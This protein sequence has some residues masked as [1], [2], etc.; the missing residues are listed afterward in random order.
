MNDSTTHLRRDVRAIF[1]AGLAAVDPEAAV[2]RHLVRRGAQLHAGGRT[3]DLDAFRHVVLIGAGKAGAPM[4]AAVEAVV[5]DRITG[6][7]VVVKYGHG[8]PL[9]HVKLIEAGHPVPDEN[10]VA[11]A[12]AVLAAAAGAGPD[13]LVIGLIS[14][15]G[16]SLLTRPA[17]GLT[18]AD[19]Q[20]TTRVLLECGATIHEINTLRKHLSAVKGGHLAQAVFPA[21]MITL[22]LSDVVGDDLD[23]IASG[24]TVPDAGT[25]ADCLSI[26]R[27][28]GI[29][30]RL[31]ATVR[32]YI[33]TGAAGHHCETPKAG[34]PV[35]KAAHNIVV[36]RNLDAL[37]AA[38]DKA[39]TLGYRPLVLSSQIQGETRQVAGVH[40]AI[41]RE[42]CQSGQPIPPP[43][44]ILSG[45]ETTVTMDYHGKGGRNQ[46]F[47]LAAALDI[48]GWAQTV[49]L[50]GGTD[51]T[52]GPTDAAGAVVDGTT[53]ARAEAAGLDARSH[54]AGHDAYPFFERLG[55]LLITGPTRTNVMDLRVMLVGGPGRSSH[56]PEA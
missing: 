26:V 21:V 31:P 11:G 12:D 17:A 18:L 25:F 22:I 42:V 20:A 15:G 27:R 14:G 51:G 8:A 36:G 29:E 34:D 24:P 6:G 2:S 50:S 56:L 32:R 48:A 40:A 39:A 13:S 41:A 16:S 1:D 44:C 53:V 45:G 3:Y 23:I 47:A 30:T 28:Y 37:T 54:L 38:R 52:D 55:D 5:G 46:E 19:K 35:F 43:A 4:A 33:E 7:A 49:I 10:S 9:Q